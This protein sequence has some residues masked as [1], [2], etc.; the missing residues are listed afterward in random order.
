MCKMSRRYDVRIKQEP[1][2]PDESMETIEYE[3]IIEFA[4]Q[5]QA[6]VHPRVKVPEHMVSL[7]AELPSLMAI[8]FLCMV[9]LMLNRLKRHELILQRLTLLMITIL[10]V[11]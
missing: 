6:G 8:N 3:R 4:K 2:E 9:M 10:T 11:C 1:E 7:M 5:V